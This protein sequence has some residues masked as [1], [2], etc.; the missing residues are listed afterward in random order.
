MREAR[1]VG[2]HPWE[3]SIRMS[4]GLQP[5]AAVFICFLETSALLPT[6]EQS[7]GFVSVPWGSSSCPALSLEEWGAPAFTEMPSLADDT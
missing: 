7:V 6:T 3:N 2:R 4:Y 5:G 1:A